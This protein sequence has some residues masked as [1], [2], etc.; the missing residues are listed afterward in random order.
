MSTGKRSVKTTPTTHTSRKRKGPQNKDLRK[1][2]EKELRHMS[3]ADTQK[4]SREDTV[5]LVHEL[6]VHQIELEMQ[7]E[8]LRAAQGKLEESRSKYADLYDSAPI[9][10]FT[11]DKNGLIIE[12]NVTGARELGLERTVLMKKSFSRFIHRGDQ[13]KFY[14]HRK[15]VFKEK[16]RQNCEIMIKR[17]D[18]SQFCAYL[19][20]VATQDGKGKYSLAKIAL[21]NITDRVLAD[22]ALKES[23][24]RWRSMTENSPDYILILDRDG[25]I[26]FINRTVPDLSKDEVLGT[27]IYKYVTEEYRAEMKKC[28]ERVLKTGKPDM[29]EVARMGSD[30]IE[31][32]FE[33]R[34]G[35]IIDDDKIMSLIVSSTDITERKKTEEELLKARDKLE[36]SVR[37]RTLDLE[38]TNEVLSAEI[39]ERKRIAKELL[40]KN[41]ALKVL[42]N[43]REEDRGELE[44]NILSNIQSL[45]QP[46]I[47]RLKSSKALTDELAYL[48]IIESNLNEIVSPFSKKLSSAYLKFSPREI[49]VANLIK[50]GRQDKEIMET[51]HI[52]FETVKTHRQNIRKKLGIYGKNTNLRTQLQAITE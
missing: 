34:V 40:E 14:L 5:K 6:R 16:T 28:F 19:V 3:S 48:N 12:C 13:D 33:S 31:R 10:Y 8:E 35:P 27:S 23:E 43:Q 1:R 37:E 52:S 26:Q 18:K 17:N 51:L 24:E 29:Y 39:R 32:R 30:G 49:Q 15:K 44:Q 2:A 11:L 41:I 9:S 22:R 47:T 4:L 50:E 21:I 42:L 7:N 36:I 46:Y 38:T 25:N 20:C 45:I